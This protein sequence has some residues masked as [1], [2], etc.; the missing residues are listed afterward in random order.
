MII[1]DAHTLEEEALEFIRYE[2][3]SEPN[4]KILITAVPDG[5]AG[6]KWLRKHFPLIGWNWK[7]TGNYHVNASTIVNPYWDS[8]K[9]QLNSGSLGLPAHFVE[10]K[11]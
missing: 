1:D 8:I 10:G 11:W 9:A 3:L 4:S 6:H 7:G 2:L 5:G